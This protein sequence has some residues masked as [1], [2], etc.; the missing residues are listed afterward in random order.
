MLIE[1]KVKVYSSMNKPRTELV[2]SFW[3]IPR[4][5]TDTMANMTMQISRQHPDYVKCHQEFEMI[6][7]NSPR[8]YRDPSV[9]KSLEA[10]TG[11]PKRNIKLWF[12]TMRRHVR[13]WSG[14][15]ASSESELERRFQVSALLDRNERQLSLLSRHTG[16]TG[17]FVRKWFEIRR[18]WLKIQI[19]IK[20]QLPR[21][22]EFEQ[23]LRQATRQENRFQA[24]EEEKM[25][26]ED[27]GLQSSAEFQALLRET[28][29]MER[30]IVEEG[31][32]RFENILK[33]KEYER[34]HPRHFSLSLDVQ[35]SQ[36]ALQAQQSPLHSILTIA[37]PDLLLV[38]CEL[39]LY[40]ELA[41][42]RTDSARK[43]SSLSDV[44][45]DLLKRLP[46]TVFYNGFFYSA[47]LPRILNA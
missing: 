16:I 18:S 11:V 7:S 36:S 43:L 26:Q 42:N 30:R 39:H 41:E 12:R 22:G 6:F 28:E 14:R 38:F 24:R 4:H 25:L 15:E 46:P 35:T 21:D 33:M 32:E 23:L 13:L 31:R 29:E 10:V 5:D 9:L 44:L 45:T 2:H 8:A 3:S 19:Y 27:E 40:L 34:K 17:G 37:R 20:S 47:H 1:T